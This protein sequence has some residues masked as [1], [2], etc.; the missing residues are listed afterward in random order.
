MSGSN[1]ANAQ[2]RVMDISGQ[3]VYEKRLGAADVGQEISIPLA[4]WTKGEYFV[5]L[6]CEEGQ[7]QKI[8][9]VQ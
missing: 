7:T 4:S 8:L 1:P 2:L 3:V 9:I 5:H 6:Y